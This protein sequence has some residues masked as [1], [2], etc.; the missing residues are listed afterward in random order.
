MVHQYLLSCSVK[1]LYAPAPSQMQLGS[2]SH[3]KH[4][5]QCHGVVRMVILRFEKAFLVCEAHGLPKSF[6]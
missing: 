3:G 6:I 1:L 5:M 4:L 2:N